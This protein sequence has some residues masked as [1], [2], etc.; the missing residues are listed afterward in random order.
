MVNNTYIKYVNKT[1]NNNWSEPYDITRFIKINDTKQFIGSGHA[2][3]LFIN[4]EKILFPI[5]FGGSAKVIILNTQQEDQEKWSV[6][7]DIQGCGEG[8]IVKLNETHLFINM[9][10]NNINVF[11]NY[12][13]GSYSIDNG[14]TWSSKIQLDLHSPIDGCEGS[15]VATNNNNLYFSGPNGLL[16][17]TELYI[18]KNIDNFIKWK[19]YK[20]I[21]EKASGYSSMV[22]LN[23]NKLGLLYTHSN[24]IKIIFNSKNISY[25]IIIL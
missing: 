3:G 11:P 12:R 8:Q 2:S 9:R 23:N 6:S 16:L 4:N 15:T 5:Y 21:S 17:R 18:Y 1:I 20:K 10:D 19:K 25:T 24:D 22:N 13:Y 14:T 7:N